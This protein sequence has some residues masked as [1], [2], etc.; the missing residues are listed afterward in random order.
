MLGLPQKTNSISPMLSFHLLSSYCCSEDFN[1][2]KRN[3]IVVK[4]DSKLQK[5]INSWGREGEKKRKK[6][7]AIKLYGV[8]KQSRKKF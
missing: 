5:V 2:C 4:I 3:F 8:C 6:Y 1:K 7:G